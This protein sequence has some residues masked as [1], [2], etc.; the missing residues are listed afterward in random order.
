MKTSFLLFSTAALLTTA[1][2]AEQKAIYPAP[3]KPLKAEY[4]LYSGELGNEQPP[5][6]TERKLSV[7][8]TGQ[9]AKDIFDSLFPDDK[10]TCSDEEGERLRSKGNITCSYVPTRGYRCFF[11][12]DLRTGRSIAGG[13]C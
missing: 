8:V 4:T 9:G 6:R 13:S 12:F 5:T 1:A 2:S 10:V 3:A 11:G 7:E